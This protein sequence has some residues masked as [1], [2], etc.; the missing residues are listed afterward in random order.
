MAF[1]VNKTLGL[2]KG[3]L[4]DSENTWKTYLEE[5]P[6][7]QQTAM[8]L[9]GP[10]LVANVLLSVI[11]SRL[12]GGYSAYGYQPNWFTALVFGLVLGAIAV[13]VTVFV[14]N[15]LAGPFKGTPNLSRAFAAVSLAVIP[16]WVAGAVSGLIPYLGYLLALAGGILSLVYLYRLMP[17]ALN[18]PQ[19]KRVVHFIT[20]FVLIIVVNMVITVVLGIG[21]PDNA[22]SPGS[23]A[24]RG[25]AT[26][27]VIGEI[28]RQSD[29]MTAAGADTYDPPADGKL[30][31]DQV[32][33]YVSVMQKTR[34]VQEE[35]AEKMEKM[36]ADLEA[37]KAA[38]KSVSLSDLRNTYSGASSIMSANNAE[39]EVVKT[40][41]G[42]WAEHAW[43]KQQ[44]RTAHYQQGQDSDA[45][46]YN[47]TLYQKYEKDL[48][49]V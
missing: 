25:A 43:V 8:V 42:N 14:F 28:T 45:N 37:K 3:G 1:D 44:L 22:F 7:W 4:L 40:G 32:E 9:T 18:V 27:G 10:L 23:D 17:L 20:S 15:F 33:G 6:S 2:I 47:Y 21:V 13:T 34:E 46:A 29:L 31:K 5:N 19:D 16:A 39:M 38:G 11:F 48:N 30:S 12:V 41:G 35:Y 24:G 26:S 36:S 49:G